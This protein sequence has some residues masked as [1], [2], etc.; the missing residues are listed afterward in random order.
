[1]KDLFLVR[2]AQAVSDDMD[3]KD[4][5]RPLTADGSI[6]ASKIGKLL[7]TECGTPDEVLASIALRTKETAGRIIEQLGY[8]PDK[9]NLSEDLYEAST[10]IMLR[11]INELDDAKEKVVL[12]AHNPAITYLA[13]YI[14][15]DVIG[16]VSP[17]GV[18]HVRYDGSW[19]EVSQS[20]VDLVKYHHPKDLG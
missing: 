5:D 8:N 15:G 20:N 14:T 11:V 13:E 3:L 7:E 1:M 9:I 10:R 12:V 19:A 6:D 4:I 17:A 18:V 16:G 2:H